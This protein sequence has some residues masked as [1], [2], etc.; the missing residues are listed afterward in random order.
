MPQSDPVDL[1]DALSRAKTGETVTLP[2]G[3]YTLDDTEL[4]PGVSPRGAGMDKT[5]ID[6]CQS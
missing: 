3:T 5:F 1:K 4:P 6:S 2:A